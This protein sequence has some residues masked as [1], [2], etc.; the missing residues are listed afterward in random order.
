MLSMPRIL[1]FAAMLIGLVSVAA[2]LWL[3][4]RRNE[5]RRRLVRSIES[6]LVDEDFRRS[7]EKVFK[8]VA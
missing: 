3:E 7:E 1:A 8:R 5:R 6:V 4:L 2:T